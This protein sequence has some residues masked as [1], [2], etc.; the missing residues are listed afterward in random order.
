ID[1]GGTK[2]RLVTLEYSASDGNDIL[3]G[4]LGNDSVHGG[5]GA[6]LIYGDDPA[7]SA[8]L[9]GNDALFGDDANDSV[10][11]NAG[12]DHLYGGSGND[13]LDGGAGADT[14]YGGDGDDSL[15]AD[16]KD[17]KLVDWFGNYN[18]FYVPPPSYGA[19]TI[20]RAPGPYD[21]DWFNKLGTADGATN[22]ERELVIVAP[23]SPSNSGPGGRSK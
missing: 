1:A 17:D 13:I 23:P 7:V 14:S 18:N 15:Y 4:G 8:S 3:R 2:R 22:A 11:G 5:G 10:Y 6:D 21:R 20:I 12:G 16:I 19:P 9:G